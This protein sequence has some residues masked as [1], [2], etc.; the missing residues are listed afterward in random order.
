[1]GDLAREIDFAL[2][3]QQKLWIGTELGAER[4]QCDPR[5]KFQIL[6]FINLAHATG[7]M[8]PSIRKR[9]DNNEPFDRFP[10]LPKLRIH[11]LI[12]AL[13]TGEPTTA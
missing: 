4:F 9:E 11:T 12:P 6:S 2:E 7:P 10:L 5:R 1:M 8:N 3:P 13:V